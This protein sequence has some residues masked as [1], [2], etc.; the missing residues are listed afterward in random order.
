MD[1]M[2]TIQTWLNNTTTQEIMFVVMISAAIFVFAMG[3]SYFVMGASDPVKRR[4]D[5]LDSDQYDEDPENGL[6]DDGVVGEQ[7]VLQP[8]QTTRNAYLP[9]GSWIDTA[10]GKAYEGHQP[11]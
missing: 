11:L 8:G 3:L 1:I 6:D 4:L 9:E 2:T 7:P 5:V 10:T